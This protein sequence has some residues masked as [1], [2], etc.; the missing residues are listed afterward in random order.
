MPNAVRN[1]VPIIGL[2]FLVLAFCNLVK[3][4]P[5]IVWAILGFLFG[6]FS[7]FGRKRDRRTDF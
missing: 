5:W 7:V 6:G 3:G 4:D 2:I 1:G